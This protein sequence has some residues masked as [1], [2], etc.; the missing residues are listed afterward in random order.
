MHG[1]VSSY[2]KEESLNCVSPT[3]KFMELQWVKINKIFIQNFIGFLRKSKMN[4][5]VQFSCM[6]IIHIVITAEDLKWKRN[7]LEHHSVISHS[8]VFHR[9]IKLLAW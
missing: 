7:V 1:E 8:C 4:L 6:I 2:I 9:M 5:G 3:T